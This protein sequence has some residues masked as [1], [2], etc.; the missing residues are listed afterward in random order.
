MENPEVALVFEEIADLLDIQ[1]ANPLRI[2]AYR[3]A[4]RTLRDLGSPLAQM[5]AMKLQALN[6][7]GKDLAGKIITIL[8]TGDLPLR[9]EMRAQVPASLRDLMM[10]PNLGPKRAL[11]LHQQLRIASLDDLRPAAQ[12]TRIRGLRGFGDKTESAILQALA[13]QGSGG[14]RVLY[15]EAKVFADSL[16][17]C[18]KQVRGIGQVEVAG[19]FR[20]RKETVADLDILATCSRPSPAMDCLA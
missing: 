1:G 12:K 9:Q 17:K 8:E 7:I 18:L 19:S 5:P 11:V 3:T 2:R 6:G 10:L 15:S 13:A 14:R 4:A 16:V 20:R